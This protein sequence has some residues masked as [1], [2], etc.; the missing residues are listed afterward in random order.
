LPIVLEDQAAKSF[1][2]L[3]R[4]VLQQCREQYRFFLSLVMPIAK[5][6]KELQNALH[7]GV[8]HTLISASAGNHLCKNVQ[9]RDHVLVIVPE[10]V[11]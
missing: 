11:R 7:V 8:I 3:L 6:L 9:C 2:I 4:S 5:I 10:Q 1:V